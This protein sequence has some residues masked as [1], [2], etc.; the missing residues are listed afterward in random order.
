MPEANPILSGH[1]VSFLAGGRK[2]VT[3]ASLQLVGGTTTILIGPNGAGKSTLLK[4]LTGEI[5]PAG[6]EIRI[7]GEPLRVVPAWRLAC[8]RAVMAQ[9]ARLVF[10]FSVY[11]LSLIHI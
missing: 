2:L 8:L 9:H 3:D 7:A 6:G 11:E 5:K 1:G 4:L 10:P